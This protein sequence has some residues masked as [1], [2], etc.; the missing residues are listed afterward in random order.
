[1]LPLCRPNPRLTNRLRS[2]GRSAISPI[3][4]AHGEPPWPSPA[5]V[6]LADDGYA[7][8]ASSAATG[9]TPAA[10]SPPRL[11]GFAELSTPGKGL[12]I[13]GLSRCEEATG[14]LESAERR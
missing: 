6:V 5:G 4:A 2:P 11:D 9:A 13:A 3:P 8:L 12:A 14:D 10:A 7:A 1:M